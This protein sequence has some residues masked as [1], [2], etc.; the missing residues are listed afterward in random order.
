MIT[1]LLITIV[2]FEIVRLVIYL[3]DSNRVRTTNHL[4]EEQRQKALEFAEKQD[5]DW[6]QIRKAEIEEL[7]QLAETSDTMKQIYDEWMKANITKG[8]GNAE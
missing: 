5:E 3:W 2:V 8:G 7:R 1:A 6:K 4:L